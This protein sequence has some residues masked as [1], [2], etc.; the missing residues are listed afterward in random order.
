MTTL[1]TQAESLAYEGAGKSMTN[2]MA[3]LMHGIMAKG[4]KPY[5]NPE[6]IQ[7]LNNKHDRVY[8][9]RRARRKKPQT[10]S[11]PRTC[12]A[13]RLYVRQRVSGGTPMIGKKSALPG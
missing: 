6:R 1:W 10:A 2:F 9:E 13:R 5:L 12:W 11:R 8:E 3:I 4:K 7:R